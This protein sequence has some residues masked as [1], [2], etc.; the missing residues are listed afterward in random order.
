MRRALIAGACVALLVALGG[1]YLA[2]R[3]H[4]PPPGGP[5]LA[6]VPAPAI[7]SVPVAPAPASP[8]VPAPSLLAVPATPAPA[9]QL[10]ARTADEATIAANVPAALTLFRFAANPDI[11][12]FDFPGLREQ[13]LMLN[14]VAAM[15]EKAGLPHDRV[16]TDAEL[17]AAIRKHGDTVE[18]YYYGHD[19]PAAELA[20]F[21]TRAD[22]QSVALD[23][24]ELL[25]RRI[26]RGE[27]FFTPG[28]R[29]ALITIP[30]AR[31][32][33]GID[34][35][36]RASILEHELS[37]GEF[38]SNPAFAAYARHFYATEMP[39]AAREAFRRF[40]V[41]QEYDPAVPDLLANETQAYLMNTTDPRLFNAG[42][43]GLSE[44]ELQSLRA[45]FLAGMPPG[46][47]RDR[48][49]RKFG[50]LPRPTPSASAAP[51]P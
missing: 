26:L 41:G 7:P 29:E 39:D 23:P 4:S 2:F 30:S 44:A 13:G 40:L 19:Y 37:H 3:A 15:V 27:G 12:V 5:R 28:S 14:R 38:F 21:F 36:M 33:G 49:A 42:E 17:D 34:A 24:Q 11:L 46:W 35:A 43:V 47:L 6:S 9:P 8:A 48:I 25:L 10:T 51:R 50:D 16:L 22:R 31:A 1:G 45:S 20:A 32:G 18:T